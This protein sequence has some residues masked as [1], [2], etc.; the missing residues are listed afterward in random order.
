MK[1]IRTSLVVVLLCL[2]TAR[3]GWAEPTAAAHRVAVV[4]KKFSAFNQHDASAIQRL[5]AADAR[6]H[7]PDYPDLAGNQP[8][9]DTYRRIFAAI[10][11]ARDE[12]KVLDAGSERVYVQFV[13]SGHLGGAPDKS[14]S[15][16][17]ISVY[18]VTEEH[19]V[20]D[21]TYYDRKM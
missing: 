18:R 21:D 8:I 14:I 13:L 7:S 5:Y 9:A 2:P 12:I 6:L 19:I 11:D 16:R 1:A 15:I 17:I 3:Q 20:E 10:P 4:R